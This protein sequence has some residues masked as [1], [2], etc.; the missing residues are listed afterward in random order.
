MKAE[1]VRPAAPPQPFALPKGVPAADFVMPGSLG[2]LR[3]WRAKVQLNNQG[4]DLK[5]GAFDEVGYVMI[6]AAADELIP[7]SRADE[8]HKGFDM[9]D[10]KRRKWRIDP[11][12]FHP[13]FG[14]SDYYLYNAAQIP[15]AL[16]ALGKFRAWGGPNLTVRGA[17]GDMRKVLTSFDGFLAAKGD[18]TVEPGK[19]A[20]VG[21]GFVARLDGLRK[22]L[23]EAMERPDALAASRVRREARRLHATFEASRALGRVYQGKEE[24]D[25]FLTGWEALV[26]ARDWRGLD[27][28]VFSHYGFKQRMHDGVRVTIANP[29]H[30]FGDDVLAVFGDLDLANDML[31]RMGEPDAPIPDA[32]SPR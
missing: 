17:Y 25:P 1:I 13:V 10:L 4:T 26:E 12:R 11:E 16:A 7:I 22:A 31:G 32:P 27:R 21:A 9:L 23:C 19:L 30:V 18:V 8:H 3:N 5:R 6:D 2:N 15:E 24:D 29:R 14:M 20:E 28:A